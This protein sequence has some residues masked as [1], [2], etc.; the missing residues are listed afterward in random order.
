MSLCIAFLENKLTLRGT[1]VALYDYADNNEKILKNKS[2]IITRKYEDVKDEQDANQNIYSK[3]TNR[4]P[5]IYYN[6]PE[7]LDK[8]VAYYSI[9]ILY[10]IKAGKKDDKLY[11]EKCK[12]I[13]HCVFETDDPHGTYYC[14]ISEWLN[15]RNKTNVPLLHHMI[16]VHQSTENLRIRLGIPDGSLV[17]GTYGG[18]DEMESYVKN[19]IIQIATDPASKHIYFIFMNIVPFVNS[20]N[21][22]F[23]QGEYDMKT[24][25]EFINTCDAMIYTR[26]WGE[27]FGLACGEFSIC[28]KPIICY[29]HPKDKFHI[30]TLEENAFLH[31]TPGELKNIL[32][33]FDKLNKDISNN[34]YKR[35]TPELV[36]NEFKDILSKLTSL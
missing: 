19:T 33:N 31:E 9:D 13:I 20:K 3:F 11:T 32:L 23:F 10:I 35:Y 14:G 18:S 1:T 26:I 36:I 25:R 16:S 5:V 4:F 34:N 17:F 6:T 22:L 2:V 12:T 28:N 30:L 24:K 15:I 8:I 21:V 29:K 7:E 27:T